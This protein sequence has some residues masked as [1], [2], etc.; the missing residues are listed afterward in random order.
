[1]Q[2][3]HVD[4]CSST[5]A[6]AGPSQTAK[7]IPSTSIVP[8]TRQGEE[9]IY[10][11]FQPGCPDPNETITGPRGHETQQAIDRV[12]Y[13]NNNHARPALGVNYAHRSHPMYPLAGMATM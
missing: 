9:T 6:I 4:D 2:E 13:I 10:I 3:A 7:R 8:D 11:F 12:G 5:G 1:M